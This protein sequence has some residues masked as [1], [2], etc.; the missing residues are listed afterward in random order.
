MFFLP[1]ALV[2]HFSACFAFLFQPT[3]S[4]CVSMLLPSG[5]SVCHRIHVSLRL[6][7]LRLPG[8]LTREGTQLVE[9]SLHLMK[10]HIHGIFTHMLSFEVVSLF[11]SIFILSLMPCLLFFALL[12]CLLPSICSSICLRCRQAARGAVWYSASWGSLPWEGK[13][14]CVHVCFGVSSL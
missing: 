4:S 3:P 14:A 10:I 12:L 11:F 8:R 5:F 6:N 13:C 2:H 7:L 9:S 1:F